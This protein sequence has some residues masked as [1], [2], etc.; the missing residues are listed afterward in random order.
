MSSK[1]NRGRNLPEGWTSNISKKSHPGQRYYTHKNGRTQW[2]SPLNN[3][4]KNAGEYETRYRAA[5]KAREAVTEQLMA[6]T[7]EW[8]AANTEVKAASERAQQASNTGLRAA[9]ERLKV[10]TQKWEALKQQF[11]EANAEIQI[12]KEQM[13][14]AQLKVANQRNNTTQATQLQLELKAMREATQKAAK[15]REDAERSKYWAEQ[16]ILNNEDNNNNNNNSG[17]SHPSPSPSPPAQPPP[18]LKLAGTPPKQH[19]RWGRVKTPTLIRGGTKRKIKK[20]RRTR[21]RR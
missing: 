18:P 11:I 8:A 12:T 9:S 2:S 10:A 1:N 20:S 14:H 13:E 6:A 4:K 19:A 7:A 17:P 21:N 3:I 5:L 15:E 16:K